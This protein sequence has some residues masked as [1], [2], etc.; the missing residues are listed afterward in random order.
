MLATRLTWN[1]PW[2]PEPELGSHDEN[3]M[4]WHIQANVHAEDPFVNRTKNSGQFGD[5]NY[6]TAQ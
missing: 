5:R 3:G 1:P 4:T 6:G 2:F